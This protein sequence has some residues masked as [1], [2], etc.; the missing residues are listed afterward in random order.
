MQSYLDEFHSDEILSVDFHSVEIRSDEIRS[1]DFSKLL[2][3]KEILKGMAYRCATLP[4]KRTHFDYT[5]HLA[6]TFK[7]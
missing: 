4:R 5:L 6:H 1:G 7:L 3:T 2:F